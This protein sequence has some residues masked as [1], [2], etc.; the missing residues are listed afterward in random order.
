MHRDAHRPARTPL[1]IS[2]LIGTAA[3][4]DMDQVLHTW[5]KLL[6][7]VRTAENKGKTE[8][9]TKFVNTCAAPLPLLIR[10]CHPHAL[11]VL[12]LFVCTSQERRELKL[13]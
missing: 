3:A 9:E 2:L 1:L 4:A 6:R 7:S 13:V 12:V 11:C 10:T 5:F 8:K